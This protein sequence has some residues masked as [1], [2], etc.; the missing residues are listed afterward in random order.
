MVEL[1]HPFSTGRAVEENFKAQTKVKMGR[2]R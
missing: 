1:D 2:C